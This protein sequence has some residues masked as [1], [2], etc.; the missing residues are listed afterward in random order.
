V[1]RKKETAHESNDHMF[2]ICLKCL[3]R[4]PASPSP[5]DMTAILKSIKQIVSVSLLALLRAL[6]PNVPNSLLDA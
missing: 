4:Q 3:Y 5:N 6:R 2:E 1:S